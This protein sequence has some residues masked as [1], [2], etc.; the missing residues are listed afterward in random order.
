[1]ARA[2]SSLPH[3]LT[4][5]L[6]SWAAH[7]RP[8]QCS[9]EPPRFFKHRRHWRPVTVLSARTLQTTLKVSQATFS[10]VC[11]CNATQ[12]HA[13]H[14]APSEARHV[15]ALQQ[16]PAQLVGRYNQTN[17]CWRGKHSSALRQAAR[18]ET[19]KGRWLALWLG[20]ALPLRAALREATTR[21]SE[22]RNA[23][24]LGTLLA[25]QPGLSMQDSENNV[26]FE[27]VCTILMVRRQDK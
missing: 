26:N 6:A 13:S 18:L 5:W 1:M 20:A 12:L 17:S 4:G 2:T 3:A 24:E 16:R 15:A 14:A 22:T 7:V 23:A 25:D 11:C 9:H 8:E 21:Q 19:D 27:T 10:A